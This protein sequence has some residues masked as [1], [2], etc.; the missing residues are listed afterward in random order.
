MAKECPTAADT[1]TISTLS[2][3]TETRAVNVLQIAN[4]YLGSRLYTHLFSALEKHGVEN[5]IYVPVRYGMEIPSNMAKN[6]TVSPCFTQLDRLIFF[7]KQRKMLRDLLPLADGVDVIHSHT[8][9]S[10]GY[11]ARLLK[12]T[13]GIPYIVAVRNT[14]VN[15]FFKY[16]FHLRRIGVRIMQDASCVV[17]LSPAYRE[18]VLSTYVP[19]SLQQCIREKSMVIP[20]GIDDFFLK[21]TPE[22]GNKVSVPLELLYAGEINSNK[23]LE[24]TVQAAKLLREQGIEVRLTAVG[25][26]QEEK[27]RGLLENTPFAAYFPRCPKESVLEHMRQSDIFVMPSHTETFGLVYAEA[28]SQ[29]IP[30]LYTRGQGF[31]G[32]FPEGTVG[33]PVSDS[34]PA[35]LAEKIRQVAE[36]YSSLSANCLANVSRFDWHTIAKEYQHIY[37]NAMKEKRLIP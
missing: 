19:T 21:N 10:G 16:M 1:E 7:S 32:Q 28:M 23:N 30:V 37:E 2:A 36:N 15:V 5:K 4:G 11:V 25:D 27:Y 9:F 34:D 3:H 29:G 24:L 26:I 35:E 14:D 17:F 33:Y 20:N 6:V 13:Y 8:V 31:D 12:K 18:H 22:P